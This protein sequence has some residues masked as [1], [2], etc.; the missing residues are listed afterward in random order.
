MPF[1]PKAPAALAHLDDETVS[2][3]LSRRFGD[4]IQ[5]AKDL[6]V[7]PPALRQRTRHNPRL[8]AWAHERIELF[9]FA[10]Q[11]EVIRALD[12]PRASRRQWAADK[13]LADAVARNHPLASVIAVLTPAARPRGPNPS[14][15]AEDARLAL[16]QEAAAERDS[17]GNGNSALRGSGNGTKP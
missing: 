4:I 7:P 6:E 14:S 9:L 12:S 5:T 2:R 15:A 10:V 17:N 16:E 1:I 13:L 3:A 8:L 11:D